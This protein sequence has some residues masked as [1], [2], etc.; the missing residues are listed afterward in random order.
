MYEEVIRNRECVSLKDL[1]VTGHDLI[2]AGI[3]AGPGLGAVLKKLL[4]LVVEEPAYNVK[5]TLLREARRIV[6]EESMSGIDKA[7]A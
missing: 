7:D 1:A 3:P 2:G 4:A 6:E 5:E